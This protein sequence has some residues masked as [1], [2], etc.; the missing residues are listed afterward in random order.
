MKLLLPLLFLFP[1]FRDPAPKKAEPMSADEKK[2]F[3]SIN[4]Y[5][6]KKGLPEIASSPSLNL[7]AQLHSRELQA[8]PP[9]EPCNL[10][11]WTGKFGEK[12]CCYTSDHKQASCMWSK[13]GEFTSYT[14]N[15]YE[16]AAF[17]TDENTDWLELWKGSPGHHGVIINNKPW[18]KTTWKAIGIAIRPPYAVVWFGETEESTQ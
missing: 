7:V 8:A 1:L 10:H 12:P 15:G 13:P 4:A 11:S 16:I 17:S 3:Q 5:R 6:K 2:L 14:G 18:E 9:S